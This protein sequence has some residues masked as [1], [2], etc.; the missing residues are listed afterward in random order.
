MWQIYFNIQLNLG[1]IGSHFVLQELWFIWIYYGMS[2]F[3]IV[4]YYMFCVHI[5]ACVCHLKELFKSEYILN[6][7]RGKFL[8]LYIM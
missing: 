5:T 7:S 8:R 4:G 6:G 3:E 2:T 1:S